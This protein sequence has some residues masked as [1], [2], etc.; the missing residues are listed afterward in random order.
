MSASFARAVQAGL[1]AYGV[2]W[3]LHPGC[4]TRGNGQTSDYQG[5][6]MHHTATAV[7]PAPSILWNG[8]RDLAGPLCNTAGEGDGT[9]KFIA[10]HPANHAGASGGRSNGP[11]PRTRAFNKFVWGHE[12]VYPGVSPMTPAQYRSATVLGAVISNILRRPNAEW[13][14]G[15]AETSIT[16]KWDPGFANGKTIDMGAFRAEVQRIRGGGAPPLPPEDDL[17]PE[18]RA[19]LTE[20]LVVVRNLNFQIATGEGDGHGKQGWRTWQGGTNECLTLVDYLRRTN[21]QL[22]QLLT[23]PQP[24]VVQTVSGMPEVALM[25]LARAVADEIDNR[26]RARLT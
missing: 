14:R 21:V 13:I 18:E 8:R 19:A 1:T 23:R 24:E 5:G 6:I 7:G 10:Y 12:I 9:I 17:T 16:G 4:E 15:H 11:L 20:I 3:T 25:D 2:R 26:N 22:N